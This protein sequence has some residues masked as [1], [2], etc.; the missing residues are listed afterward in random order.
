MKITELWKPVLIC[1]ECRSLISNGEFASVAHCSTGGWSPRWE[2]YACEH[3]QKNLKRNLDDHYKPK[4]PFFD[5]DNL[6]PID[7]IDTHGRQIP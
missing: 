2:G 1:D 7:D 3:V 4:V 5:S 6:T